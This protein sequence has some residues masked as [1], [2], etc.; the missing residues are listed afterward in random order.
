MYR[1]LATALIASLLFFL[2]QEATAQ[3]SFDYGVRAGINSTNLDSETSTSARQGFNAG[4]FGTLKLARFPFDLQLEAFYTEKGGNQD[5]F[6]EAGSL[7]GQTATE[8]EVRLVNDET[9]EDQFSASYIEIPLLVKIPFD[10]GQ[11]VQLNILGGPAAGLRLNESVTNSPASW[12][13]D[14]G[15]QE[16]TRSRTVEGQFFNDFDFGAV[17]GGDIQFNLGLVR[18]LVDVRYVIGLTSNLSE[19]FARPA[20]ISNRA[21]SVSVGFAL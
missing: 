3:T 11:Q 20:G 9:I 12:M 7:I 21:L 2:P 5:I 18:P 10:I 6:L 14:I 19:D 15:G 13:L 16:E 1:I 17:V 8:E 4:V